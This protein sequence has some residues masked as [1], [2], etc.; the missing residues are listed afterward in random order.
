ARSQTPF[1]LSG[2]RRRLLDAVGSHG[3]TFDSV[4]TLHLDRLSDE[5][6]R[7]LVER[8]AA[9]L[10]LS[11]NEQTRDLIAQQFAGNPAFITGLAQAARAADA[12]LTSF[13]A[14]QKLY[15]DELLG[16]R[17]GRYFSSALEE[18]APAPALRRALVR[19]L[20]ESAGEA[21]GRV[22]LEA[23]RRKLGIEGEELQRLVRELHARELASSDAAFIET[24]SSLIWR[25]YLR[26]VYRL[27]VAAE[28]RAQV[29]AETLV[30]ALKRAPQTMA[31]H[32]R[33]E[34]ALKLRELLAR[35]DCQRVPAA[36]LNYDR[37]SRTYKGA[38]AEEMAAGLDAETELIRLPQIAHVAACAA[39]QPPAHFECDEERCV[40]AHGF[41]AAGYTDANQIVWLVAEIES[42][43]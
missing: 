35:F 4:G 42:K 8:V 21:G 17:I 22:P 7:L 24:E 40:V 1:V 13:L 30:L 6:A 16:G 43:L 29:V 11:V 18:V 27:Q 2:L 15:T 5:A 28:P 31:R 10:G 41:D 38:T 37:F 39:F 32:Y 9:R 19:A 34:A 12:S 14:C 26:A 33:R 36:L 3:V 25:D 23:W 20:Q